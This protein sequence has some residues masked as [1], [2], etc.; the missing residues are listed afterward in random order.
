[1]ALGATIHHLLTKQDPRIEP[2]F[3]F[4]ERP[5]RKANPGVSPELDAIVATALNYNPTERFSSAT[6]MKEA[7][8]SLRKKRTGVLTGQPQGPA[9]SLAVAASEATERLAMTG[10]VPSVVAP[11]AGPEP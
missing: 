9:P 6:A 8:L 1:Y 10:V 3:S 2:P 4:A 7:L 11:V 5:L